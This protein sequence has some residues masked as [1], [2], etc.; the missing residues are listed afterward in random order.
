MGRYVN[1]DIEHKFWFGVQSSAA[2]TQFGGETEYQDIPYEYHSM[3]CFDVEVLDKKIKY[4]NKIFNTKITR[5]TDP[6]WFWELYDKNGKAR[7]RVGHWWDDP[8]LKEYLEDMADICLGLKIYQHIHK[9]GECYF[10]AQT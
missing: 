8:N 2:A 5:E 9:N 6:E 1:G 3:D 4:V 10:T 7:T